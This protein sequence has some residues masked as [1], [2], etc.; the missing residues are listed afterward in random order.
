MQI[1][2]KFLPRYLTRTPCTL[3]MS[4][5]FSNRL[6]FW[7]TLTRFR[8][9]VTS[10][11]CVVDTGVKEGDIVGIWGAGPIGV[12]RSFSLLLL[13]VNLANSSYQFCAKWSLL[14]G[15]SR[16]IM[17]DNVKWR[18]DYVKSKLPQVELLNF[19]EHKDVAVRIN[20]ITTSGSRPHG[21][22]VALECA[23]GEYAKSLFHKI[24]IATG[25]ETDTSELLNEMMCEGFLR[26][27]L[28]HL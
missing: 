26:S 6:P 23:A 25:L 20:E 21:L 28:I 19:D 27:K 14:K 13:I 9:S 1:S 16:V 17:I 4:C 2:S 10:Y 11:H 7:R 8:F 24:E 3:V 18:L 15:A 5:E 12:V 22:D